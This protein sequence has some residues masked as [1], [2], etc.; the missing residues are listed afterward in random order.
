MIYMTIKSDRDAQLL[1]HDLDTLS[2]WENKWMMKFHPGKYKVISITPKKKPIHYNYTLHGQ[3][4]HAQSIK[5]LGVTISNDLRW[6]KHIDL[7]TA[8]VNNS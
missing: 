6:N 4:H 7:V 5:Y 8:K 2:R 3:L 1:Q